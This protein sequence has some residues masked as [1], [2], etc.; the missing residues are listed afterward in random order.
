MTRGQKCG[1]S[2]KVFKA[3]LT[4]QKFF[5]EADVYTTEVQMIE[6]KQ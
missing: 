5:L 1:F 2:R 3:I 6:S 4:R